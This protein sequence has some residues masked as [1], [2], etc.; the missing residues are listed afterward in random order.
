M[1]GQRGIP[2]ALTRAQMGGDT[3]SAME[4][5]DGKT[6]RTDQDRLSLQLVGSRVGVPLKRYNGRLTEPN[7]YNLRIRKKSKLT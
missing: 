3:L 7:H 2:A 5:L 6:A 1:F 4:N